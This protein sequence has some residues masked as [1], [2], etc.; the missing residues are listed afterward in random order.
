MKGCSQSKKIA[1]RK[2]SKK[3][4]ITKKR[5]YEKRGYCSSCNQMIQKGGSCGLCSGQMGGNTIHVGSAWSS[6][7]GNWPGVKG[8][9]D[10]SWLSKN[11]YINGDPQYQTVNERDILFLNE[12][13][14]GY[15]PVL[16]GGKKQ[17]KGGTSFLSN[18]TYGLGSAYNSLNGFPAPVNPLP[19]EQPKLLIK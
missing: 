11:N 14:K 2:K 13:G 4:K 5:R 6:E 12:N 7:L 10:G 17:K 1:L 15:T 8:A 19:Y 3:L 9:H 18:M 16:K